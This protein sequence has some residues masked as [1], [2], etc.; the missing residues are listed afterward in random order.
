MAKVSH[1]NQKPSP[2]PASSSYSD[3]SNPSNTKNKKHFARNAANARE[4]TR[5]RVLSKV[6][7][8]EIT[9]NIKTHFM[10]CYP[11][12]GIQQTEECSSMGSFR[13]ETIKI[14]YTSLGFRLHQ[15]SSKVTAVIRGVWG[16][17]LQTTCPS[18]CCGKNMLCK[19]YF[20]TFFGLRL[21]WLTVA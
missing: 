2:S 4:R 13:Y 10:T 19:L 12:S 3:Y 15:S 21:T 9:T 11:A 6:S 16:L 5:M 7:G 1:V 17:W 8:L 20:L 14:G 18:I